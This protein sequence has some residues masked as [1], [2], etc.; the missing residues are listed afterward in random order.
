MRDSG[1][2]KW[3]LLSTS[4]ICLPAMAE[5]IFEDAKVSANFRNYYI[6]RNF[7]E[8]AYPQAKAEEW[9]QSVIMDARSGFTSGT[10][11]FGFDAIGLYSQ[12]LDGGKGT[13][14]T[15][16][17][18]V[19]DGGRP[20]DDFGRLALAV[21]IRFAKTQARIGEWS[22]SLPVIRSDDGR[23]LPQTFRGGADRFEGL[24][25]LHFLR[26]AIPWKQPT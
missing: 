6:N 19:H 20:A 12:K 13:T 1:S 8:S 22:V 15:Q 2:F 5:G 3:L 24:G 10:V 14:N 18:P 23:S 4:F 11:G 25:K 26:W 7:T 21:K 17:L 9:T 16:L